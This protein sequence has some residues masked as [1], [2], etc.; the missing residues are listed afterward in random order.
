MYSMTMTTHDNKRTALIWACVAVIAGIAI[1][2]G[3]LMPDIFNFW[4]CAGVFL[5]GTGLVSFIIDMVMKK[6]GFPVFALILFIIGVLL[7]AGRF[8]APGIGYIGGLLAAAALIIIGV[9]AGIAVIRRK[10]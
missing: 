6:E 1:L 2:L 9:A 7:L 4:A 10:Y 3:V 8:L 5:C